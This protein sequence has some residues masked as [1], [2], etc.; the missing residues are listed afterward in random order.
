M[1]VTLEW[2]TSNILVNRRRNLFTKKYQRVLKYRVL[3]HKS[4]RNISIPEQIERV[5]NFVQ[6]EEKYIIVKKINFLH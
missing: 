5:K 1:S 6:G 4:C 3:V 2:D